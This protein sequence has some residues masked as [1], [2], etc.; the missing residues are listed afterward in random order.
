MELLLAFSERL[1]DEAKLDRVIP[2]V[3]QLLTDKS[4]QI[5]ITALRSM[6]QILAMVNVVSPINAYIFPEY[7]L[8][9]LE[10]YLSDSSSTAKPLVRMQYALCI[11]TLAT[12]AA[13]YLDM[14]QALRADGALPATDP[15]AECTGQASMI[16][17]PVKNCFLLAEQ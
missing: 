11:G 5:R 10:S 4:E 13:R 12:T 9:R 1:T 3:A 14:I 2:Y 8:P 17:V 7:V 16:Q 6:T 15:E